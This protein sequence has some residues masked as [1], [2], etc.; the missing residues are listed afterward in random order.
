L[1]RVEEQCTSS[2][3]V[4]GLCVSR[5]RKEDEIEKVRKREERQ[6]EGREEEEG[7]KIYKII[8]TP[9]LPTIY[10]TPSPPYNY[11]FPRTQS[12]MFSLAGTHFDE[13]EVSDLVEVGG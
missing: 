4:S 10:T 5:N 13:C 9:N 11:A 2:W 12:N 7:G 3:V 6:R 8:R 1:S